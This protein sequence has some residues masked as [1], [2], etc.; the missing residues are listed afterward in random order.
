MRNVTDQKRLE[1][2]QALATQRMEALLDL[3]RKSDDPTDEIIA[4][5]VEDAIRVTQ[6][7]NRL[8]GPVERG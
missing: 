6:S 8:P 3:N 5:V 1:E 7:R 2:E 4:A